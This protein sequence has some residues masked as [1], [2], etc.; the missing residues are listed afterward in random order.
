MIPPRK[1]KGDV[2]IGRRGT[3][4]RPADCICGSGSADLDHHALRNDLAAGEA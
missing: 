1:V 3:D 4:I 2:E